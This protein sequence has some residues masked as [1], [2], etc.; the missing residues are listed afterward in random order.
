[1]NPCSPRASVCSRCPDAK[2]LTCFTTES[3]LHPALLA[4]VVRAW[5]SRVLQ[6]AKVAQLGVCSAAGSTANLPA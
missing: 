4:A 6:R 2:S 3:A 5:G 1:M